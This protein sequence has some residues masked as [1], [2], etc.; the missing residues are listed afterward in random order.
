MMNLNDEFELFPTQ[1]KNTV[2]NAIS[3]P[4]RITP[5]FC[6]LNLW[7]SDDTNHHRHNFLVIAA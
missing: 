1:N 3:V 7:F 4:K 5:N 6:K 2:P